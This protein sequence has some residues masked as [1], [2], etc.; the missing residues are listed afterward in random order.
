MLTTSFQKPVKSV[1]IMISPNQS[2]PPFAG[3]R[4]FAHLCMLGA[5]WGLIVFVFSPLYVD[6]KT[7]TVRGYRYHASTWIKDTFTLPDLIYDRAFFI[8][9]KQYQEHQAAISHL[10]QLKK[11]PYLGRIIKGKWMVHKILSKLSP[12]IAHLPHTE[13]FK[14]SSLLFR[15]LKEHT[16][17]VLK[18]DTGSQGKGVLIITKSGAEEYSIRGRNKLN[19]SI[20]L[21]FTTPFAL[22][23]WLLDFIG[24]RSYLLQQYLSLQTDQGNA[25]DIRVLMQKDSHGHWTQTGMA[26]RIGESTSITSNLHGGGKCAQV[27]PLLI[28]QFG[29]T[30]ANAILATIN[31]LSSLIPAY[32]EQHFGRL[33]ELGLDIGI[34]E[35]GAVWVIEVN[36]KPGRAAARWFTQPAGLEIAMSKPL[37]YARFLLHKSANLG[38]ILGG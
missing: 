17:V 29:S 25:F 1:G 4:F 3:Q 9:A 2:E 33:A 30:H 11:I 5:K 10:Q 21:H 28:K 8:N 27:A 20:S 37:Q 12:L 19:E 23:Q 7:S 14:H 26:A 24:K 31:Q 15:R 18:P 35:A 22:Q 13:L 6:Y 16:A 36:S 34:D 38:S 32:L